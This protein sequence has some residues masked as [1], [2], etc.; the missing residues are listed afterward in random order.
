MSFSGLYFEMSGYGKIE[1]ESSLDLTNLATITFLQNLPSKLDISNG[2]IDFDPT[3]SDFAA[4]GA[5]L[6]M[7][8]GSGS[9][10]VTGINNPSQF[11]VKSST[12]AVIDGS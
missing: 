12:G 1:F 10:F 11:I 2:F 7:Y 3:G 6:Y 5:K 9:T 8:F 4:Y